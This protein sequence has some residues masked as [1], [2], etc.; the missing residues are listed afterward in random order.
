MNEDSVPETYAEAKVPESESSV[1]E[2]SPRRRISR[3]LIW[4]VVGGVV[5]LL[6]IC[7]VLI[8]VLSAPYVQGT[9]VLP[10]PPNIVPGLA[11]EQVLGLDFDRLQD[12][13]ELPHRGLNG[14]IR[15]NQPVNAETAV[16]GPVPEIAAVGIPFLMG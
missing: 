1:S 16:V 2:P 7:V 6:L 3:R 5:A 11:G 8:A 14:A 15:E 10:L 4:S 9:K 12:F 13:F